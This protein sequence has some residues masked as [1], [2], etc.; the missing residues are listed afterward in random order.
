MYL[1]SNCSISERVGYR[2]RL[3]VALSGFLK[4]EIADSL[5]VSLKQLKSFEQ[6]NID[7]FCAANICY[8]LHLKGIN[9]SAAWL[10]Y[11]IGEPPYIMND[12]ENTF[13]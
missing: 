1:Q 2:F 9:C 12:L 4:T 6:G 8:K 11:G 13:S 5:S 3:I 7:N 10:L